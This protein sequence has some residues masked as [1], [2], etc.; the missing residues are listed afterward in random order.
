MTT[1]SLIFWCIV[2][3]A[4][5]VTTLVVVAQIP[6]DI[7]APLHW[8]AQ[9]EVD[10]YGTP[11][12]MFPTALIMAGCNGLFALC[13]AFSE[14]LY[15]LGLVHGISRKATRPFLCGAAVVMALVWVG[16]VAFW[17]YQVNQ[18]GL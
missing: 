16:I 7:E 2:V 4:P 11:R 14:R 15:A 10:R 9:G 5:I 8:N 1:R 3:A 13:Y 17:L 12:E 6:S 18:T